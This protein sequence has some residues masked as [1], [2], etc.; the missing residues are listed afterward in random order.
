MVWV[1]ALVA[2]CTMSLVVFCLIVHATIA[3]NISEDEGK[4]YVCLNCVVNVM[5]V[6]VL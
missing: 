3:I 5:I 6:L 2:R 4:Y 1:I